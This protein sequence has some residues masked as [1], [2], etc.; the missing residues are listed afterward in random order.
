MITTAKAMRL[1]AWIGSGRELMSVFGRCLTMF[2][3]V[4]VVWF[5]K[6]RSASL[7]CPVLC[8]TVL[9]YSCKWMSSSGSEL[10]FWQ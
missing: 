7:S 9:Y 2:L 5:K 8:C 1:D 3:F 6:C 10:I 4:V